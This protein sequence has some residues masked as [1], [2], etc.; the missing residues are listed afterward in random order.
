MPANSATATAT[1]NAP[2]SSCSM[3]LVP[4]ALPTSA[5][6]TAPTT[7]ACDTGNAAEQPAPATTSGTTMTV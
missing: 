5:S 2:P 4:A 1:P 7:A 6:W 3:L